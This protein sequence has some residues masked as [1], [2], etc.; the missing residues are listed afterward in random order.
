VE[1]VTRGIGPECASKEAFTMQMTLDMPDDSDS[2]LEAMR[3]R[4]IKVQ[5]IKCPQCGYKCLKPISWEQS[6]CV[7]CE[8]GSQKHIFDI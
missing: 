2:I 7:V 6:T 4:T 1:S 3:T 8:S 5:K